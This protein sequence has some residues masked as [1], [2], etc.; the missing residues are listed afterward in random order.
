MRRKYNTGRS[1]FKF[2][3]VSSAISGMLAVDYSSVHVLTLFRDM[4]EYN[5]RF[6]TI[7]TN[8]NVAL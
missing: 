3:H 6:L 2:P 8:I 4:N 5:K 1:I 7:E